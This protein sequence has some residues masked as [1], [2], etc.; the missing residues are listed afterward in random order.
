MKKIIVILL[1]LLLSACSAQGSGGN[2]TTSTTSITTTPITTTQTTSQT[3]TSTT[4]TSTSSTTTTTTTTSKV[5][6]TT[7]PVVTTTT[8]TT[9]SPVVVEKGLVKATS[10]DI[11]MK[12]GNS[13]SFIVYLGTSRCS[14]CQKYKPHIEEYLTNKP[15]ITIYY[16]VLDECEASE[17]EQLATHVGLEYT[18]T[19]FLFI[20]GEIEDSYVGTNDEK[21]DA[22]ISIL[23]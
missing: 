17:T 6:T 2:S 8:T 3:T 19:T 4:V 5:T 15:D 20:N 16:V 23:K 18:P 9:T 11:L 21:L 7:T 12:M 22:M 1:C 13:E 10:L 14:A